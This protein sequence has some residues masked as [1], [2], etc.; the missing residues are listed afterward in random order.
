MDGLS[1]SLI[2]RYAPVY[3]QI[4]NF[5]ITLQMFYE[6][7]PLVCIAAA[8]RPPPIFNFS[9]DLVPSTSEGDSHLP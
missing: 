1:L 9:P 7:R 4:H 6:S 2:L 8:K 5:D 3:C